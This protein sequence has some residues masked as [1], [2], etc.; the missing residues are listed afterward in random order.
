VEKCEKNSDALKRGVRE[1]TD[2]DVIV[3]EMVLDSV[4]HF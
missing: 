1:E 2:T 4:N 3:R